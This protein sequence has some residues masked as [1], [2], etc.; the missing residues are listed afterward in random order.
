MACPRCQGQANL[1]VKSVVDSVNYVVR[2]RRKGGE[3]AL[4]LLKNVLLC[5]GKSLDLVNICY[6]RVRSV[7]N[8]LSGNSGVHTGHLKVNTDI[9]VVKIN[10]VGST[11]VCKFLVI[12]N[13]GGRGSNTESTDGSSGGSSEELTTSSLSVE[14]SGLLY[15]LGGSEGSSGTVSV[16]K[17]K[18]KIK[19]VRGKKVSSRR[20]HW[21]VHVMV[22]FVFLLFRPIAVEASLP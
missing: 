14:S 22:I 19:A 3:T 1:T 11:E 9:G 17:H 10:N 20:F 15:C 2:R 12:D 18:Q 16:Q 13:S 5:V 8:N 21:E 7:G 4:V 6:R